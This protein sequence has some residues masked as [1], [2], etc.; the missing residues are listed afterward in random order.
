MCFY[1]NWLNLPRSPLVHNQ[2][3]YILTPQIFKSS[4]IR[5]LT[6]TPSA[7]INSDH[8]LIMYNLKLK[9]RS[10]KPHKN[11]RILYNV[12]KLKDLRICKVYSEHLD[13]KFNE[14]KKTVTRL[15][16]TQYLK[17]L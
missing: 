1:K 5:S 17:K 2:I 16:S 4:I 10:N 7:D 13:V 12:N 14:L 11:K 3:D 6:I 8:D 9:L 15:K